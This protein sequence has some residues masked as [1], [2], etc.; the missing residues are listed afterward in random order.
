MYLK[1]K[2]K[3]N[4]LNKTLFFLIIL[5]A[6]LNNLHADSETNL[7]KCLGE[8]YK[9]YT[10]C[11]GSY[12]N[13]DMTN[14][15]KKKFPEKEKFYPN[16]YYTEFYIGE[17][18]SSPGLKNGYGQTTLYKNYEEFNYFEGEFLNDLRNGYGFYEEEDYWYEGYFKNHYF[19]G[20]GTYKSI[21][22]E[23]EGEWK[24]GKRSGQGTYKWS[25]GD[26]YVGEWK[27]NKRN[28]KGTLFLGAS[29]KVEGE[30]KDSNFIN[31]IK[32]YNGR[33]KASWLFKDGKA[34]GE[35]TFRFISGD[36]FSVKFKND[37]VVKI[38]DIRIAKPS[39]HSLQPSYFSTVSGY[40]HC[41]NIWHELKIQAE[42]TT[43]T[44]R[45]IYYEILMQTAFEFLTTYEGSS[46]PDTAGICDYLLYIDYIMRN[47]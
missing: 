42:M 33:Y 45:K 1:Y 3:H 27:D 28:G 22:H 9:K 8:N 12:A 40:K 19:H 7:P 36:L 47:H 20:F 35:G 44:L 5:L 29:T 6:V 39:Y 23:Y 25:D 18:G 16:S 26:Y 46:L 11:H 30:W 31:G 2:N 21:S 10:N 38:I 4:F 15:I 13:R 14:F 41:K 24:E 43:G 17:F 37:K 34:N 32:S